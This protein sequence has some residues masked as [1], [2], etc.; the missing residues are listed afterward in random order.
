MHQ[1]CTREKNYIFGYPITLL[2]AL[3]LNSTFYY[4]QIYQIEIDKIHCYEFQINAVKLA[5]ST[6][7]YYCIFF[8]F[9]LKP[10]WFTAVDSALFF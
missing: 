9:F 1:I 7:A 5:S 6:V 10:V 8:N 2:I 4:K 3:T